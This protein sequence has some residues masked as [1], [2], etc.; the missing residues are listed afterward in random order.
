MNYFLSEKP[1]VDLEQRHKEKRDK[2]VSDRVIAIS[3]Q[4]KGWNCAQITENF[5]K[6]SFEVMGHACVF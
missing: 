6:I 4:N 1:Q 3:P 5:Q 2:R